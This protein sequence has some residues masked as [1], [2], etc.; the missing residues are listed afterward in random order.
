MSLLQRL[1]PRTLV[2]QILL[3]AALALGFAQLVNFT[4]LLRASDQEAMTQASAFAGGRLIFAA[5]RAERL[6][7]QREAL[8]A[9][10]VGE[11]EQ[12]SVFGGNAARLVDAV[13]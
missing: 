9:L 4:L 3:A 8:G 6:A 7:E 10:G 2:G 12:A 5:D 11:S 13:I 1:W